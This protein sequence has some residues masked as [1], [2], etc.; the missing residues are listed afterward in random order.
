MLTYK[1]PKGET[2][3][4][5]YADKRGNDLYVSSRKI[6]GDYILYKILENNKL[7]K[8]ASSQNPLDFDDIVF[9]KRNRSK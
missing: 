4:V 6:F 5:V 8:V 2:Q 9:E 1:L 7:S 3:K